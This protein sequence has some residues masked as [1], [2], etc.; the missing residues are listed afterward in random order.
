MYLLP[1]GFFNVIPVIHYLC[2]SGAKSYTISRTR[3]SY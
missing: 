3:R 2:P 1:I